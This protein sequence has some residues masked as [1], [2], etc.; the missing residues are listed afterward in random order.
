MRILP[1]TRDL[2]NF[3]ARRIPVI[4]AVFLQW[5]STVKHAKKNFLAPQ[6]QGPQ[7]ALRVVGWRSAR[8]TAERMKFSIPHLPR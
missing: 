7:H 4:P 1:D 5:D 6:A 2:I 3:T 8:S